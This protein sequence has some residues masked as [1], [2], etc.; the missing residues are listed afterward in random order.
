VFFKES[1][2]D[3]SRYASQWATALVSSFAERDDAV[4]KSAIQTMTAMIS[5]LQPDELENCVIPVRQ[6]V[7]SV[8]VEGHDL[9]GF[10]QPGGLT[11]VFAIY[12][13][14]IK[15][16]S[17][18]EAAEGIAAM[19]QRTNPE[20]LKPITVQMVGALIRALGER[21]P[22][23]GKAAVLHAI[24]KLLLK[25]PLFAKP[26]IPQLQR[27]AVKNLSDPVNAILRQN[28]AIVIGA[29]I[30]MQARVD[31]LVTELVGAVN[32]AAD[33]GVKDGMLKALCEVL[34]RAGRLVG[35]PQ[36]AALAGVV[37]QVLQD[38]RGS[39]LYPWLIHV[40]GIV[41]AAVRLMSLLLNI[42]SANSSLAL[43][44]AQIL[45]IELSKNSVVALNGLLHD[46]PVAVLSPP[47]M[48]EIATRAV[49]AAQSTDVC[50]L[51]NTYNRILSPILVCLP[52]E[53][54]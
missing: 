2:E 50:S 27:I 25:V 30:P 23:A 12:L 28:A 42:Q 37:E 1:D 24:A 20:S 9:P 32:T 34:L 33:S 39:P 5:K 6:A 11:G 54:S 47:I 8:S 48:E 38:G 26:F 19:V 14:G 52:L 36:K 43:V 15:R 4:L 45:D 7:H 18:E 51:H 29:L 22:P 10:V 41:A 3:F 40:G 46:P 53:S 21:H 17:A 49:T 31:P 16:N 44:R 35:E 13:A